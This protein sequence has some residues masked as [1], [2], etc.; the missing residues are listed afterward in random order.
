MATKFVSALTGPEMDQALIDMAYHNSEAYAVGTRNGVPVGSSDVTYHNNSKY[1]A[2]QVYGYTDRAEDAANRA[3]AAVPSGTAGAVFFDRAQTL[4]SAQQSQARANIMAGGS[5][6]NLLDNPFFTV[7]QRGFTSSTEVNGLRIVDRWFINNGGGTVTLT[8]NGLSV[9]NTQGTR[10]NTLQEIFGSGD[11]LAG[12]T[13]TLSINDGGT[14]YHQT[15]VIPARTS[16][17][18]SLLNWSWKAGVQLRFYVL[19]TTDQGA[20]NVQIYCPNGASSYKYELRSIKLEL[21]SVSTL[22]NDAPPELSIA[23]IPCYENFLRLKGAYAPVGYAIAVST[24]LALVVIPTPVPMRALP[25][26]SLSGTLYFNAGTPFAVT[27]LASNGTTLGVN[28]IT[29][30][31]TGSFEVGKVYLAQFRDANSYIDLSADL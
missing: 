6:P 2:E 4:T 9:D 29:Q 3:E 27:G 13:V 8:S 20:Y 28:Q 10:Y 23:R 25:T 14:I 5:N 1:W 11:W 31:V 21:G 24:T 15:F 30:Q 7:N 16:G 26:A 22:A 18:Q 19:P 17:Y 12:K